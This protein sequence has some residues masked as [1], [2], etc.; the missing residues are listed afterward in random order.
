MTGILEEI[1]AYKRAFVAARKLGLPLSEIAAKAADSPAPRDFIGAL[2]GNDCRLIAEIKSASPSK[3]VIRADLDPAVTARIYERNGAAAISVLT[4]E[5]YFRGSIGRLG[6]VRKTVNLPLLRKDFIIDPW[7]VYESRVHGA[8]ALLLIAAC[9]TDKEIRELMD[10]AHGLGLACLVE[11]HNERELTRAADLNARL[12]GIN[13]RDLATFD[14][15]LAVTERLSPLVPKTATLVSESGISDAGHV[16]RMKEAG[17]NAVLV[18]EAILR[19]DDIGKMV[20]ELALA[21]K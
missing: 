15:D 20:R 14:T 3:G 16:R 11:V 8:D 21:G 6:L 17:A 1:I 18:G 4:D 5:K 13:N 2:S 12:I 10:C 9:L 7:Q 19:D